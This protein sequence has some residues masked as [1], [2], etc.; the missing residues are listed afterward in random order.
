[1][2]K[3]WL[4][5]ALCWTIAIAVAC[6]VKFTSL[7][8]VPVADADKGVHLFMHFGFAILWLQTLRTKYG[9]KPAIELILKVF[10]ASLIFGVAI[11]LAQQ[12]FTTTRMADVRDV[13]ANSIGASTAAILWYA[14]DRFR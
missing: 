14:Y 7:P 4:G 8:K 2:R 3:Y 13:L 9:S 10:L 6:L 1:M 11:E 12:T 5:L